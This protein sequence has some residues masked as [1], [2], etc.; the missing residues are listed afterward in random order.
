MFQRRQLDP[1]DAAAQQL[2]KFLFQHRKQ[3]HK[4]T[5][6]L[7]KFETNTNGLN[8]LK[9]TQTL[10]KAGIDKL[11]LDYKSPPETKEQLDRISR[12]LTY[13]IRRREYCDSLIEDMKFQAEME[14]SSESLS[15]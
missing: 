1:I 4:C 8:I 9:R 12:T 7:E 5:F 11:E 10:L 3:I 15:M 6:E 13:L 14:D 2:L